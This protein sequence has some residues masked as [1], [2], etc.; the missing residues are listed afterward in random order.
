[1]ATWVD[2]EAD[3]PFL[4]VEWADRPDDDVAAVL[5]QAAHVA[6]VAFL[7]AEPD[8]VSANHKLAETLQARALH[9]AGYVG[10]GNAAGGDFPVTVFPMDWTVKSL[11]RPQ[12][13]IPGMW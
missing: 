6:C 8:T 7:G 5:L 10:S 11:L 13:G 2:L 1:M 9:R 3:A 4:D 12:P